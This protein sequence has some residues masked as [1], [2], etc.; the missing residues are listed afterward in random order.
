MQCGTVFNGIR[1]SNTPEVRKLAHDIA[2]TR[3]GTQRGKELTRNVLREAGFFRKQGSRA[4]REQ[5]KIRF[6]TPDRVSIADM[7]GSAILSGTSFDVHFS[8]GRLLNISFGKKQLFPDLKSRSYITLAGVDYPFHIASSASIESERARGL[9]VHPESERSEGRRRGK[10]DSRIRL[11]RRLS[12]SYRHNARPLSQVC[13]SRIR[14][15]DRPLRDPPHRDCP[16]RK[17]YRS[18][19]SITE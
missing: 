7:Q 8:E 4:I 9:R 1:F 15:T 13:Q 10:P 16:V 14:R 6:P 12:V 2:R 17:A 3:A 18:R 11:C 19:H 5:T